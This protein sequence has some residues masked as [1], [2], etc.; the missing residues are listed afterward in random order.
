VCLPAPLPPQVVLDLESSKGGKAE[1]MTVDV[2]LVSAG[3]AAGG[4]WRTG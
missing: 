2:V 1:T 4:H 3:E